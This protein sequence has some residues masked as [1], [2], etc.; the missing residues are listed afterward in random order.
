[1]H[2]AILTRY[3]ARKGPS[4][5]H[6]CFTLANNSSRMLTRMSEFADGAQPTLSP[7]AIPP[8]ASRTTPVKIGRS[9]DMSSSFRKRRLDRAHDSLKARLQLE[10]RLQRAAQLRRVLSTDWDSRETI[11]PQKYLRAENRCFPGQE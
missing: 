9:K 10:A 6:A 11:L 3:R 5:G 7:A 1:M 8:L 2:S 4:I